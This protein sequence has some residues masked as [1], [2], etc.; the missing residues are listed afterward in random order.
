MR[1]LNDAIITDGAMASTNTISSEAFSIEHMFGFSVSAIWTGTP[2]GTLKLQFANSQNT[3]VSGDWIDITSAT[4]SITGAAGS[5]YW[6][7]ANFFGKW[8]RATYTNTSSTGTLQ[9][10]LNAKGG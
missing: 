1:V 3:P 5:W 6:N 4:K 9:V 7:E 2:N 8:I 10:R